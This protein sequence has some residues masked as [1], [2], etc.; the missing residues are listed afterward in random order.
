MSNTP[1]ISN[2]AD[3]TL[4]ELALKVEKGFEIMT[5]G[6]ERM[7]RGFDIA[8][9]NF[10]EIHRALTRLDQKID[11]SIEELVGMAAR[12]FLEVHA[13]MADI[14]SMIRPDS[15]QSKEGGYDW[16]VL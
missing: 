1:H 8:D 9:R 4:P 13:D 10:N 6:F 7:D 11:Y 5:R 2:A 14:K 15:S 16:K 12:Q 3:I